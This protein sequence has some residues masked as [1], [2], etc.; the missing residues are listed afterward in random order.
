MNKTDCIVCGSC[1][2]DIFIRPVP[3]ETSIGSG[4]LL[5]VNPIELTTGGMVS[6][7]SIAFS[8][9]GMRA[10]AFSLVGDDHWSD[11]IRSQYCKHEIASEGL[12]T[13]SGA[14]TSVTAVMVDHEGQRSFA[15][16]VGAAKQMDKALYMK[17][18]DLFANSRYALIG[19]YPLMPHLLDDLADVLAAIRSTGCRTAMDAA[20]DG[21]GMQPLDRILPHLDVYVPSYAEASHQTGKTDPKAIIDCLRD[22]GATGLIGVKLGEQGAMLSRSD[23]EYQRIEAVKPPGEVMDTTGA[24]D[25]FYAGLL[26]G[27]IRG[28]SD[29]EAGR[30]AAATGAC[31]VTAVGATTGLR[32]YSQ[33]AALAG[34]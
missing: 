17:H 34:I 2:V 20:G 4:Q 23:G 22:A 32:D 13:R 14:T 19:Y 5:R 6:N 26:T 25:C 15:H 18:L 1:V 7:A 11:V 31:C 29:R 9:L 33:T 16:C 10:A 30:L 24:G 27:L 8:K 28:N 3:L 21:G 12:L